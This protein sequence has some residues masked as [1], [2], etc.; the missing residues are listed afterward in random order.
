MDQTEHLSLP[1][2][3]FSQQSR[4]ESSR[5]GVRVLHSLGRR[6]VDILRADGELCA[7]SSTKIWKI[8][9]VFAIAYSSDIKLSTHIKIYW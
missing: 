8:W 1:I 6:S 2:D 9:K 3:R 7:L 5:F 4:D